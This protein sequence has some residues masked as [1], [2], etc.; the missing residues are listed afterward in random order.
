MLGIFKNSVLRDEKTHDDDTKDNMPPAH[1]GLF[2][3]R[4]EGFHGV[5]D[6]TAD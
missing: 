1:N 6:D 2:Q 4:S 3:D 5:C